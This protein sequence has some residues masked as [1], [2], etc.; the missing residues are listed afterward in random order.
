MKHKK[1][2]ERLAA[3]QRAWERMMQEQR[4]RINPAAFKKPG[5]IQKN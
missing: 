2:R 5:S 4:G 3:R 1:K